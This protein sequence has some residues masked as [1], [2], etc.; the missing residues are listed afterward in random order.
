MAKAA[1]EART[2]E[3]NLGERRTK[4]ART[5]EVIACLLLEETMMFSIVCERKSPEASK[6]YLGR[7]ESGRLSLN[8]KD[9]DYCVFPLFLLPSLAACRSCTLLGS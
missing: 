2:A 9:R 6:V 8:R 5:P 3:L 7:P 4:E 1:R